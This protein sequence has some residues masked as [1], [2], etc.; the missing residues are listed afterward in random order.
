LLTLIGRINV[1]APFAIAVRRIVP[2]IRR[3]D[4]G[5]GIGQ[6]KIPPFGG[7]FLLS[8]R[9]V[10][11]LAILR[12]I[13]TLTV[14]ILLLL[15]RLLAATLLLAG[16][17]ARILARILVLLARILILVR[18]RRSPLLNVVRDNLETRRWFQ[19]LPG[20]VVINAW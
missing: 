2:A 3:D 6:R 20:S 9:F 11:E 10:F 19:E 12:W 8:S 1:P 4:P 5:I 16:L 7:T 14:W 15:A 17:L 13:L 18:H